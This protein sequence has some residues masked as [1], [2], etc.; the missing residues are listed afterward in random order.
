VM[1]SKDGK[2]G[3]P[4]ECLCAS[5]PITQSHPILCVFA[6]WREPF[7]FRNLA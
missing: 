2:F 6:S 7:P 3:S 4:R 5:S 1:I